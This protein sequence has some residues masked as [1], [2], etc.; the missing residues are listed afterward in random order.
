M[1]KGP[2]TPRG[3]W[4]RRYREG[5]TSGAGS[6]GDEGAF[7]ARYVSDVLQ[8]FNVHSMIDWGCGDGQVLEGIRFPRDIHYRGVDVSPTVIRMMKRKFPLFRFCTPDDVD[9][10]LRYTLALSMDVLFHFPDNR[11]YYGYL[12]KLFGSA[13]KYVL[14]YSTDYGPERTA[15]HVYRRHFTPDVAERYGHEWS[16][17]SQVNGPGDA[18][19]YLYGRA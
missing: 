17:I 2:Y 9:P 5:R 10:R 11:D 4:D 19:F 15:K 7:K 16:M 12:D 13:S 3:Y 8:R 6:E 18:G 14:I 1:I